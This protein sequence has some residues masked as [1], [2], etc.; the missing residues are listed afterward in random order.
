ML[1]NL[2]LHCSVLW[3]FVLETR[4]LWYW[5]VSHKWV[6]LYLKHLSLIWKKLDA[7]A[8][9]IYLRAFQLIRCVTH[10]VLYQ[11]KVP[12]TQSF[13]RGQNNMSNIPL[14]VEYEWS[15][16]SKLERTRF[17]LQ[18]CSIVKQAVCKI[19]CL[20]GIELFRRHLDDTI[21]HFVTFVMVW[22]VLSWGLIGVTQ[23]LLP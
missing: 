3:N 13:W 4:S 7:K 1:N 5:S 21:Q 8:P 12:Y 6:P 20:F 10:G 23:F 16:R 22:A 2:T 18:R 9:T 15:V 11:S 17:L 19:I 14:C